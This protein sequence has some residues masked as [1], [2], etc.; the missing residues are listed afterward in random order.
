MLKQLR[1]V[2]ASAACLC[3]GHA[4][5]ADLYVSAIGSDSY[6]VNSAGTP[7]KTLAKA[8]L[9]VKPGDTVWIMNGTYT[10][11]TAAV[12]GTEAKPITWRAY[13]D[14]KPEVVADPTQYSVISVQAPY[15]VFD[16][17]TVTGLNDTQTQAQAEADYNM[18][19]QTFFLKNPVTGVADINPA[20]A[21]CNAP[22][23][24]ACP[25]TATSCGASWTTSNGATAT[26]AGS[27]WSTP[28]T[29][30]WSGR[31]R[32]VRSGIRRSLRRMR[33]FEVCRVG[34]RGNLSPDSE[35]CVTPSLR[36]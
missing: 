24:T 5:A 23:T 25:S 3:A 19:V 2:A 13:A 10:R 20:T 28:T 33:L 6:A 35:P 14:H 31:R 11:F 1:L 16:G 34:R 32:R 21:R 22:S 7:W 26:N 4:L 36:A 9:I 29:R 17:L 27:A 15:Q 8:A 30:R 12:A 18:S